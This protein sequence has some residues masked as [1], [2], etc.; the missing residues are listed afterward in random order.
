[1]RHIAKMPRWTW[2]FTKLRAELTDRCS[3]GAADRRPMQ[4]VGLQCGTAAGAYTNRALYPCSR[5]S[6]TV[7]ASSNQKWDL[8]GRACYT[9]RPIPGAR[10]TKAGIPPR[11]NRPE[12]LWRTSRVYLANR[13]AAEVVS[14]SSAPICKRSLAGHGLMSARN[15]YCVLGVEPGL[16]GW[17]NAI[18]Y[19][20]VVTE[21]PGEAC[22][23]Q[24]RWPRYIY[25][26]REGE[27]LKASDH[28]RWCV[29][30]ERANVPTH[31]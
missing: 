9:C 11:W 17:R 30:R 31:N 15:I 2:L 14:F 18:G 7:S 16:H 4:C 21:Y 13:G 5:K 12:A 28:A 1:M 20:T 3:W 8:N 26:S 27:R 24:K 29:V 25:V 22:G 6:Y 23:V 19:S 10:D